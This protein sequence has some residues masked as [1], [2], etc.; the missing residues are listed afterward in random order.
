MGS[1]CSTL[2]LIWIIEVYYS[3][4]LLQIRAKRSIQLLYFK[5]LFWMWQR[6]AAG[7]LSPCIVRIQLSF[8]EHWPVWAWFRGTGFIP[9]K[10]LQKSQTQ[11]IFCYFIL[12]LIKAHIVHKLC[13]LDVKVKGREFI[14]NANSSPLIY[15]DPII[16]LINNNQIICVRKNNS[17][18]RK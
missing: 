7:N 12:H 13:T 6:M 10:G 18:V 3:W 8:Q 9:W 11:L 16:S 15:E 4:H 5:S 1:N 2:F 14:N 17:M